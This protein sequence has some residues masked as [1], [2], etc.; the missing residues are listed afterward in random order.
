MRRHFF[1]CHFSINQVSFWSLFLC[2]FLDCF[3]VRYRCCC[4][5]SDEV[6]IF[7]YQ[8][9]LVSFLFSLF[10]CVPF[11]IVLLSGAISCLHL[12]N[13]RALGF[14]YIS[15]TA[16]SDATACCFLEGFRSH[17]VGRCSIRDWDCLEISSA[18]R[19]LREKETLAIC[20]MG[21]SSIN[22]SGI[23]AFPS[24]PSEQAG[25]ASAC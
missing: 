18:V 11:S 25:A 20:Y 8:F 15:T 13:G 19:W 9:S 14:R 22:L 1:V 5:L 16:P 21:V 24:S 7:L 17:F 4:A 10:S 6:S 23:W 3:V 2:P 12:A